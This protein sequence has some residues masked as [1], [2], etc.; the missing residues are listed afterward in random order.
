MYP[1]AV[2]TSELDNDNAP[3]SVSVTDPLA[4]DPDNVR[5]LIVPVPVTPVIVPVYDDEEAPYCNE[6]QCVVPSPYFTLR[7]S[8]SKPGSPNASIGFAALQLAA[9]SLLNL[10]VVGMQMVLL[11]YLAT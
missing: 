9:V 2:V 5:P 4:P 6:F 8:V 7:V 10:I 3:P 1:K 11:V